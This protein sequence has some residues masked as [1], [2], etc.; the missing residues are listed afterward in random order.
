[1]NKGTALTI[2]FG[3]LLAGAL[4]LSSGV[5]NRSLGEILEG[6]TAQAAG[7]S[8]SGGTGGT[9]G[10]AE[11]APGSLPVGSPSKALLAPG[12]TSSSV[13]KMALDFFGPRYGEAA[14]AGIVGNLQQESSLNPKEQNGYLAQ[15]LGARL[16]GLEAFA[17]KY[18][19]PVTDARTQLA[20]IDYELKTSEKSTGEALKKAK[21]PKEAA[22]IF[23]ERFERPGE[24]DLANREHYAESWAAT[25]FTKGKTAVSPRVAS[26]IVGHKR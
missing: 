25:H 10:A 23:S 5:R 4:L 7:A 16:S 13:G 18:K 6:E 12:D 15:W 2:G 26:G 17:R 24:P 14:A 9:P 1:V 11:G 19:V 8:T 22:R 3:V 21:T 20:Y